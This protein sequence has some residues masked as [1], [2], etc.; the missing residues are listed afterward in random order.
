MR[1]RVEIKALKR[2]CGGRRDEHGF[3]SGKHFTQQGAALP[4]HKFSHASPPLPFPRPSPAVLSLSHPHLLIFR[5]QLRHFSL[6]CPV[7]GADCRIF[8]LAG[9]G[10]GLGW[11]VRNYSSHNPLS[12]TLSRRKTIGFALI[13]PPPHASFLAEKLKNGFEFGPAAAATSLVGG[14]MTCHHGTRD[15]V[16]TQVLVTPN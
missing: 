7:D 10:Q 13:Q 5:L 3:L 12:H 6:I 9:G 2:V 15:R 8:L 14:H 4:P 16:F 1:R 11:R